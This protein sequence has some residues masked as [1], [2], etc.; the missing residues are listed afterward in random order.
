VLDGDHETDP[1]VRHGDKID[2]DR[3]TA[4]PRSGKGRWMG[5]L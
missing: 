2:I 5:E 3:L 1:G 4:R